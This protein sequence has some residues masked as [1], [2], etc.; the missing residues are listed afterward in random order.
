MEIEI[1][2]RGRRPEDGREEIY[3][4]IDRRE[5]KGPRG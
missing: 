2:R 5:E 4:E 1:E 3:L